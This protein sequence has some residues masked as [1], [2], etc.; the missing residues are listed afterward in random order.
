MDLATVLLPQKGGFLP[1]VPAEKLVVQREDIQFAD[2]GAGWVTI[3]VRV[4]NE[5]DLPSRPTRLKI[6]AAPLGAFVPGRRIAVLDV[7]SVAL[8][9]A[10]ELR[11]RARRPRVRP[12]GDLRNTRPEDL[13]GALANPD[14][15]RRRLRG[16]LGPWWRKQPLAPPKEKDRDAP[17]DVAPL[18]PPDPLSLVECGAPHWAGNINVFIGKRSVERHRAT[19]LRV[20]PGRKNIAIFEV[21]SGPDAYAFAFRGPGAMWAPRLL[22]SG[23]RCIDFPWSGVPVEPG[24]WVNVPGTTLVLLTMVPPHECRQ[25][26]LHVHVTQRSSG[27]EAVVEFSLDPHAAGPGCYVL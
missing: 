3:R 11:T 5:G 25:G 1:R 12:L 7:P 20:Y 10:V 4:R 15:P 27:K 6:E 22:P 16:W 2:D 24:T 9:S 26:E 8:G 19:S 14:P 17:G 18:L 23:F 13:L 21:G